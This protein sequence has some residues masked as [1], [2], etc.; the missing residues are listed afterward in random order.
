MV[1]SLEHSA[2]LKIYEKTK[3]K[4]LMEES[5][6][7]EIDTEVINEYIRN[8]CSEN[9]KEILTFVFDNII[10]VNFNTFLNKFIGVLNNVNEVHRASNNF[11]SAKIIN[12]V[13]LIPGFNIMKSTMW[14][15]LIIYHFLPKN[16]KLIEICKNVVDFYD[17]LIDT[18]EEDNSIIAL[19]A[20]DCAYSGSQLSTIIIPDNIC[21]FKLVNKVYP[22][23]PYISYIAQQK[24]YD[25]YSLI[26]NKYVNRCERKIPK[27]LIL[28]NSITYIDNIFA[29][30]AKK[31]FNIFEKDIIY[32]QPSEYRKKVN[33]RSRSIK[34]KINTFIR[35]I[36]VM[37]Y[38]GLMIYFDH[39]IADQ[40]STTQYFL[41]YSNTLNNVYIAKLN[42]EDSTQLFANLLALE[43]KN[44]IF[45][46]GYEIAN[47]YNKI[48]TSN[49]KY[50]VCE[51]SESKKYYE[52][53]KSCVNKP[54]LDNPTYAG[55]DDIDLNLMPEFVCP[56]T[57]YKTSGFYSHG[58]NSLKEIGI[59]NLSEYGYYL[60]KLRKN[61]DDDAQL[62]GGYEKKYLIVKKEYLGAKKLIN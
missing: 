8:S 11:D 29:I 39:K 47:Y 25:Q 49:F 21:T 62:V 1:I 40:L 9:I 55:S 36:L 20:D 28:S 35:D 37:S 5:G 10:Y 59:N 52:V 14:L 17:Y 57:F 48:P 22:I 56:K 46:E 24:F 42:L 13:I 7:Y 19:I 43:N 26:C 58:D 4:L 50:F 38:S 30:A 31:N 18:D 27:Y 60:I 32:M 3:D 2:F 44:I 41:N 61:K 33:S 16:M 53:I 23:V 15:S 45:N 12:V 6:K 34:C 51:L 54:Y